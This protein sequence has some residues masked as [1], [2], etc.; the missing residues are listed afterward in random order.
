MNNY[1]SHIEKLY[2]QQEFDN[3]LYGY[4]K[5]PQFIN[6][7]SNVINHDFQRH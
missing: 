2:P 6:H 5:M 7:P 4:N 1:T 3:N